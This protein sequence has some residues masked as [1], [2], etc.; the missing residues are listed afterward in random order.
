MKELSRGE[1]WKNWAIEDYGS[2]EP[3]RALEEWAMG[4]CGQDKMRMTS[5]E[6]ADG[7]VHHFTIAIEFAITTMSIIT[8]RAGP[9]VVCIPS[10][11]MTFVRYCY[12]FKSKP[13]NS[14]AKMLSILKNI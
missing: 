4:G 7:V 8:D 2:I 3:W 9:R 6:P 10:R 11:F 5:N 13:T 1:V 14:G 12:F